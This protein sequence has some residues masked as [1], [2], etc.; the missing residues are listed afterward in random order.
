MQV[1][2]HARPPKRILRFDC[3]RYFVRTIRRED[4][5]DRWASWLSDPWAIR[6]LNLR[7]RILNKQD[8]LGYI[9][10]FDQRSNLLAGIFE[11]QTLQHVGILRVDVDW[12]SKQ[13]LINLL[14][15][16]PE[17]RGRGLM[18]DV[19]LG[20]VDY[21]FETMKLQKLTASTLSRNALI[22]SFLRRMGWREDKSAASVKSNSD[23]S[24]LDLC[25]FALTAEAWRA[26]KQTDYAKRLA[27]RAKRIATGL[28]RREDSVGE[29]MQSTLT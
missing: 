9:R 23:G 24:M 28:A 1:P 15:G 10:K 7:S 16:E 19:A 2:R 8:I 18:G 14:I 4:A 27:L 13:G 26:W 20:M 25:S 12:Q 3:G 22:V 11:K 6:A 21:A 17:H 29:L 5:S